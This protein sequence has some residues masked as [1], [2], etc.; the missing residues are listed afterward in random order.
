MKGNRSVPKEL[1]GRGTGAG[2][3]PN[4]FISKPDGAACC[5]TH[6][7]LGR[8]G[9]G[10]WNYISRNGN[11]LE[12]AFLEQSMSSADEECQ[13]LLENYEEQ[14][15][16]IWPVDRTSPSPVPFINCRWVYK[17]TVKWSPVPFSR[18][19][20]KNYRKFPDKCQSKFVVFLQCSSSAEGHKRNLNEGTDVPCA[21]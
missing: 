19:K 6:E 18:L 14:V 15:H 12:S 7:F 20:K 10:S 11:I 1:E 13:C 5:N 21:S 17:L 2:R 8:L 16:L 4:G 3:L 9:S